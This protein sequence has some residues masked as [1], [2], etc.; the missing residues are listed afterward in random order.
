[1]KYFSIALLAGL[2]IAKPVPEAW[3]ADGQPND[4][5]NLTE[6]AEHFEIRDNH[7]EK[8]TQRLWMVYSMNTFQTIPG[9]TGSGGGEITH[10]AGFSIINPAG[11]DVYTND[12]GCGG[13][14]WCNRVDGGQRMAI[15]Q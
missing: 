7:L 6:L 1:M 12:N 8:R 10:L 11:N 5:L 14:S 2:A 4:I 9:T 15:K 3:L 13:R